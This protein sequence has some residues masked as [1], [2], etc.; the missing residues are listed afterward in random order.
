MPRV[1]YGRAM[2]RIPKIKSELKL[3][4]KIWKIRLLFP[5]VIVA[6]RPRFLT[7]VQIRSKIEGFASRF[8]FS[9]V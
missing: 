6:L 1:R 4:K 5:W 9:R 7:L 3:R 8:T 2:P